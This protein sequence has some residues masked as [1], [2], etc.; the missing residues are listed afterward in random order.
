MTWPGISTEEGNP[1]KATRFPT[2]VC[3]LR[4]TPRYI[5]RL[6][7]APMSLSMLEI[8]PLGASVCFSL[9]QELKGSYTHKSCKRA[10]L[11]ALSSLLIIS[12]D[13]FEHKAAISCCL[14]RPAFFTLYRTH[15]KCFLLLW[16]N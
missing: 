3:G 7:L 8:Q 9:R 13:G 12:S 5:P 16:T 2:A 11:L 1:K 15:R 14:Y 10:S 4:G 6:P